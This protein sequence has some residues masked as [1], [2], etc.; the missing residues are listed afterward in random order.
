MRVATA[1][2]CA[3]GLNI[4]NLLPHRVYLKPSEEGITHTDPDFRTSS[5]P[6]V[7]LIFRL[8]Q[9]FFYNLIYFCDSNILTCIIKCSYFLSTVRAYEIFR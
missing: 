7:D 6:I 2:Y 8:F 1:I 3:Y 9:R 5:R 4:C